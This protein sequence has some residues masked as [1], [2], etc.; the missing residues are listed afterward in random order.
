MGAQEIKAEK[1]RIR[2]EVKETVKQLDQSYCEAADEKI[3]E[4]ILSL[5]EY[6]KADTVFCFVSMDTE[7]D[8]HRL[9]QQ[10]LKDG[11]RVGVPRCHGLGKMDA[12][13]IKNLEK[14][15]E[16]GTW[17]ILEPKENCALVSPE[18][19]Q[20]AIVPCCSCSH[21]G[22]R[23]GYGG[24][25]YDRYLNKTEAVR[26]IVCREKIM[27]EDIPME[28]HDLLMDLVISEEGVRNLR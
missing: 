22:K 13:E 10:M 11:K 18:E 2:A 20:L 4:E 17:G 5:P 12:Y 14:D 24:G 7:V 15:L 27:R 8:T 9:I 21:E 19:F 3:R 28:E 1:K 25:F 26:A 23:L 6:Q 16:P